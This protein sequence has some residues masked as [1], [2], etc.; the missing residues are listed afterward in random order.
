MIIFKSLK[1]K[2]FLSTGDS[3]THIQLD[4]SASTLVVGQNGAGKSTMLDALSFALFGKAHRSVSKGQLVNSVNNKNCHVEVEF[5]A[6]GSEYKVVRGIKPTKFEIW[7]DDKVINQDS[8][9]KEYQ[10]VLEQNILKLNHKSFHQ[11]IVLGSSSFVPFMQLPANHRREVI[12]DLLDINVFSKMNVILKEKFSVIKEKVRANQSDLENLEYKIRTQTKYVE[13]L[14]KNKRDNREEK[15]NDITTI[16]SQIHDIRSTMRP[17]AA[18]GLD[19]LKMEQD[20]CNSLIIQIKQYDKTFNSK[21]KEL[22]KEK[23]FYEDNSTCPTCEQGIETSFK[24]KKVSETETKHEHF[25]DARTKASEELT[26]LNERMV[27]VVEETKK[28]QDLVSEYDRKQIEIDTLQKQ[29]T[30]IQQYLSKQDETTTDIAEE[31]N[32]L[33]AQNDDREILRDIKGDLAEQVAYSMVITELL[34]DTGIKTKIV[35]EYL[36]VINQLV[37]KY[38]QV[39]DFFVSFNLDEQF[40]ETIRSRHRDAFSYDS[41]SEGEKQRIDLALLFTWRQVAKMKNSVATNLLILDETFDSSLD[42]EGIDN[43]TSI[44]DTLDGDTNTYVI[45]HK[46]ELL[47]GK[48]E[49]KIEFVKKGNFSSVHEG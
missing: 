41:F 39:L 14:E 31:R 12:E 6:L 44:L 42:V 35:K 10:K 4:K 17:I 25:R 18:G 23:T 34:K 47:D 9:S 29:I 8:H 32:T 24:E 22:E 7:R 43:L 48:F 36:P 5:K 33:T 13:S 46:G 16:E 1:Y 20:S 49:D 38:L 26:R 45:S 21:L 3:F 37:N 15:L 19:Q 2:N 30:N 11:I 27:G 28:L 40:K